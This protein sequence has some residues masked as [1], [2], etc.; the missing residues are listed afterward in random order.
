MAKLIQ[1]CASQNDLFGLD[2]DGVVYQYNFNTNNWIKLDDGRRDR[3]ESSLAEDARTRSGAHAPFARTLA[4]AIL[5]VAGLHGALGIAHADVPTAGN[6]A[7]CNREAQERTRGAVSAT[8]KDEAAAAAARREG[9]DT[10][11]RRGTTVAVTQSSDPQIH[12][13]EG[14]GAKDAA[15]RAAYRVCMRRSGF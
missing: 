3:R 11:E 9:A 2:G 4:V 12:G 7:A 10:V 5:L 13:M 6:I 14:E 1:I 15:Y 8:P